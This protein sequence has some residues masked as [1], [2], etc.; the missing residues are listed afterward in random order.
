ME[1]TPDTIR[2]KIADFGL[3]N[4]ASLL[5]DGAT[6]PVMSTGGG[7]PGFMAP[8]LDGRI[9]RK[10]VQPEPRKPDIYSL[11]IMYH[12]LLTKEIPDTEDI[13]YNSYTLPSDYDDSFKDFIA[14]VIHWYPKDRPT[15]EQVIE[16]PFLKEKIA[17][18]V[19]YY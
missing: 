8:E 7:T 16:H 3:I 19:K 5:S 15:I 4:Q 10:K 2:I 18:L 17:F 12:Y 11:G 13:I 9:S 6:L 1:V 14:F